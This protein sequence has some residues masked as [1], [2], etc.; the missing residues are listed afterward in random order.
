MPRSGKGFRAVLALLAV[1]AAAE[2]RPASAVA[3]GARISAVLVRVEGEEIRPDL[4]SLVP[5]AD[6]DPFLPVRIDEAVKR[7]NETGLFSDIEVR[8]EGEE[9]VRLTFLLT[10][11]LFTRRISF[12]G[13]VPVSRKRLLSGLYALRPETEFSEPRLRRAEEELRENLRREGFFDARATGRGA[14]GPGARG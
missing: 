14:A 11:K 7:I 3:S 2:S 8:A 12:S 6:G 1:L 5:I 4:R 13:E 10:R 9:D